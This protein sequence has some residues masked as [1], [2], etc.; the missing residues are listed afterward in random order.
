MRDVIR[1]EEQRLDELKKIYM[2]EE[3]ILSRKM[4]PKRNELL[5]NKRYDKEQNEIPTLLLAS[6]IKLLSTEESRPVKH[7]QLHNRFQYDDDE[8]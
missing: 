1:R 7:N 6:P 5:K 3:E 2:K 8:H 4:L